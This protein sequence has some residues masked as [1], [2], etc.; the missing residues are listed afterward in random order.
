VDSDHGRIETRKYT[1]FHDIAWL[2]ERHD[3]PGLNGIA[4]CLRSST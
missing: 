1:V 3:W 4:N 2:K